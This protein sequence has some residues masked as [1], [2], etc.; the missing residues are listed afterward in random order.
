[1]WIVTGPVMEALSDRWRPWKAP[2]VAALLSAA[3]MPVLFAVVIIVRQNA[4]I[5]SCRVKF[6]PTHTIASRA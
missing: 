6:A 5:G 2:N 1:M 4:S 3:M